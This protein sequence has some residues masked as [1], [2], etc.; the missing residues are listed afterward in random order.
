M[1]VQ[2]QKMDDRSIED[3]LSHIEAQNNA[4]I[5]ALQKKQKKHIFIVS[6]YFN[7]IC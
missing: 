7:V 5:D 1:A 3:R 2:N 4:I 6:F